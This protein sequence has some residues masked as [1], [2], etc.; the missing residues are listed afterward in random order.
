MMNSYP[1]PVNSGSVLWAF[2][3]WDFKHL[4]LT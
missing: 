1:L 4:Q 3:L 2:K